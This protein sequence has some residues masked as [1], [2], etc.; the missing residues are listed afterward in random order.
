MLGD[1]YK[2]S[3][4]G[5]WSCRDKKYLKQYSDKYGNIYSRL[6]RYNKIYK[7]YID[8]NLNNPTTKFLFFSD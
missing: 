3:H 5:I 4:I 1:T 8:D 2:Y 6:N 7:Y